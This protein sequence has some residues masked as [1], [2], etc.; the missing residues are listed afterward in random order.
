M[1]DQEG[2]GET[3]ST[4]PGTDAGDDTGS[5]ADKT[6]PDPSVAK[7]AE[8]PPR[9]RP[10][11]GIVDSRFLSMEGRTGQRSGVMVAMDFP[12]QRSQLHTSSLFF[13]INRC[14]E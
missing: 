13:H 5:K 8:A 11:K 9:R 10:G 12:K 2:K 6:S 3:S 7:K 14:L 4:K 1:A